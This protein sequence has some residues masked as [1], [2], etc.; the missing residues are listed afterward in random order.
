M[1]APSPTVR[2]HRAACTA[3]RKWSRGG[4]VGDGGCVSV[5]DGSTAWLGAG[6]SDGSG[7][8]SACGASV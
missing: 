6:E 1:T 5:A 8:G 3:F 2:L 4:W 7:E